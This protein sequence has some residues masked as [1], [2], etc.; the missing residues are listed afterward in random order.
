MINPLRETIKGLAVVGKI[1]R[2]E[3]DRLYDLAVAV[4]KKRAN[5]EQ[6]RLFS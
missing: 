3:V 2:D 6:L 1:K 4:A 5:G